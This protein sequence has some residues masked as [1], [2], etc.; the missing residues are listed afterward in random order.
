MFGLD[1]KFTLRQ[2]EQC[3]LSNKQSKKIRDF[4]QLFGKKVFSVFFAGRTQK[5]SVGEGGGQRGGSSIEGV[6]KF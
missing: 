6:R 2:F 3:P 1:D 4:V 5:R